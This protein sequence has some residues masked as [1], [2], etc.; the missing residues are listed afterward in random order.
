LSLDGFDKLTASMLGTLTRS[1]VLRVILSDST[2]LVR[3]PG[4][5][6]ACRTGKQAPTP[7]I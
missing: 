1:T 4:E 7:V 6:W 5:G 2:E 3:S